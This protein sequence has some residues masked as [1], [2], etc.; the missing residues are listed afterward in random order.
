MKEETY[1]DSV[2]YDIQYF[3]VGSRQERHGALSPKRIGKETNDIRTHKKSQDTLILKA[4]FE[5]FNATV[6]ICSDTGN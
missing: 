6:R 3:M 5:S 4:S 1:C 2:T